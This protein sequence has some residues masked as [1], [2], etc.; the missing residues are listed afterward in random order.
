MFIQWFPV[1]KISLL[2]SVLVL[3]FISMQ[4]TA[5]ENKVNVEQKTQSW[6]V[7]LGTTRVIYHPESSGAIISV[8]NPNNYPVLVQGSVSAEH[9]SAVKAPFIITPPLFRLNAAQQSQVRVVMTD[10]IAPKDRESLY[11]LCETGIP[12]ELGDAWAEGRQPQKRN[13]AMLDVKVR[14]SQCIKLLVRP[15]SLTSTPGDVAEKIVWSK[16]GDKIVANNPTPFYMNLGALFV[17]GAE[18]KLPEYI[19]PMGTQSYTIPKGAYG[20]VSWQIINDLG[21]LSTLYKSALN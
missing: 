15:D 12:P 21:G 2:G 14:L 19:P 9:K 3:S 20:D 13:T 4:A 1:K 17:G 18:I 6:G 11:W 16:A 7:N 5:D 10:D 8:S